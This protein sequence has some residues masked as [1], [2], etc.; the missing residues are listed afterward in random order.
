[1]L[2]FL[3]VSLSFLL[4]GII[5]ALLIFGYLIYTQLYIT[6]LP[7]ESIIDQVKTCSICNLDCRTYSFC[8]QCA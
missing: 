5:I 1:M 3:E 7:A 2:Y 4:F 6:H 8:P